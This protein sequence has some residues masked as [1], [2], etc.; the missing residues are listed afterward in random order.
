M[1]FISLLFLLLIAV[2]SQAQD[3]AL[4]KQYY[5]NGEF[6][7]AVIVYERLYSK[8]YDDEIYEN[9]FQSL[10]ALKKYDEAQKLAKKR[11]AEEMV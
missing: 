6:D 9:Y 2:G 11:K 4:A 10:L 7:K 1:R 3:E 8:K 5:L